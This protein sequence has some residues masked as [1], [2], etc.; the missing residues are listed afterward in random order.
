MTIRE[1][2]QRIQEEALDFLPNK[3][4]DIS[5]I[6]QFILKKNEVDILQNLDLELTTKQNT[7]LDEV[8]QRLQADEPLEYIT[9][10]AHFF[11]FKFKTNK[12]TL[13]PR[14]ETECLVSLALSKIHERNFSQSAGGPPQVN[15]VDVGTGTGCIIISLARSLETPQARYFATEICPKALKVAQKNL[16]YHQVEDQINLKKGNLLEPIPSKTKF[17]LIIANPP[18]IPQYDLPILQESVRKY[19]PT[20]A[21]DGGP[22]GASI[23]RELLFQASSRLNPGGAIILELQSK[24]VERVERIAE[25]FFPKAKLSIERDSFDAERFLVIQSR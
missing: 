25:R 15:I 23:I 11:G 18:Y 7:K 14:V 17:D 22:N 19:E 10:L 3:D 13:I 20:I 9:G 5:E 2:I 21:L 8:I 4:T 12:D 24:I 16:E 6:L 1:A